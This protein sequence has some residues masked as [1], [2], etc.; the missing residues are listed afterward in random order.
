MNAADLRDRARA[1]VDPYLGRPLGEAVRGA[2]ILAGEAVLEIVLGFPVGGYETE[3]GAQLAAVLAGAGWSGG[4]RL[5]LSAVI[6]SGGVQGSLKPLPAIR[7]V[8]AIA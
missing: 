5:K 6:E 1:V 7:N 3:L 8:V 4:V 2:E